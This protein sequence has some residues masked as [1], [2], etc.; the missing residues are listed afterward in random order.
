[1]KD[2]SMVCEIEFEDIMNVVFTKKS[3][4]YA[5]EKSE[6]WNTQTKPLQEG[7]ESEN[8]S[9]KIIDFNYYSEELGSGS[10]IRENIGFLTSGYFCL[11]KG[12]SCGLGY[13][14]LK[15]YELMCTIWKEF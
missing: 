12:L 3:A 10:T 2:Y 8:S 6:I 14:S 15:K 9:P 13:I 7:V 5:L 4:S 1:M 11:N